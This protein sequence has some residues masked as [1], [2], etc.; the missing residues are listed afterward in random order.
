MAQAV[1]AGLPEGDVI[2]GCSGGADSLALA[3][4]ADW[5]VRRRGTGVATAVVV[6]HG[7]QAGSARI[8]EG[9]VNSLA[10]YGVR[11]RIVRVEVSPDGDG[12]E[13]AAR[14]A[15]L[16]ALAADGLPVLLGHTL[17]D[18]AETVL[19][20]L[21]RGSGTR[22]LAGWRQCAARSTDRCSGCGASTRKPPAEP[23]ASTGGA[24]R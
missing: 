8:A 2:V 10:T 15:R 22:S 3:L 1:A 4:G 7:L 18:Q 20:G 14:E 11:A 24:T 21:L 16:V 6:D 17:D 13:A 9:A 5:A 23:G 19:L 12:V